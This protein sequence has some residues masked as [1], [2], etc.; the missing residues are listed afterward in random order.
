MENIIGHENVKIIL[1]RMIEEDKVGHAYM[2]V[3]KEGIGKKLLAIEFAKQIMNQK[4]NTFNE[5]DFKIILPESDL[6]KVEEIR[7][8]INEIYLKPIFSKHKILIIDDADK[9]NANAQNALLK[10]LEEP[11][12]Y[13]T[14]RL[15]VSHKERII[16]T[17]LSRV[18]EIVFNPLNREELEQIVSGGN[19]NL[20]YAR[21]SVSKALSIISEEYYPYAQ[22]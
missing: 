15:I 18:T 12:A 19:I 16:K 11:P 9:M 6:I 3:G 2:F 21:G 22:E 5:S 7:N 14:L 17:I 13:A 4:D 20:E 8:L 10:V 1:K